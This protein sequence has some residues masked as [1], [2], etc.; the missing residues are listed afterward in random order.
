[1]LG[2]CSFTVF[3]GFSFAICNMAVFEATRIPAFVDGVMDSLH[4]GFPDQ[5]H[6]TI[7][8]VIDDALHSS[9]KADHVP[10]ELLECDLDFDVACPTGWADVGD[11]GACLA[12]MSYAGPCDYHVEFG[13]LLPMDKYLKAAECDARFPCRSRCE[14]DFEQVCPA[15][16]RDDA[17]AGCA[18]PHDY[19][20]PC[21]ARKRFALISVADRATFGR[22][23]GV[24]WP[25]RKSLQHGLRMERLAMHSTWTET[26]IID[27]NAPCP[28][29]WRIERMRSCR[30]PSEY[31]GQCSYSFTP[32]NYTA[33]M[34]K[35][36]AG[37]C[38][39]EWPCVDKSIVTR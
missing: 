35:A 27:Y 21:V 20:G 19:A 28:R 38:S 39:A 34:K 18:A 10:L 3:V 13:K 2:L 8:T 24:R 23:C 9:A 37:V 30:A 1:M 36:W 7:Q 33:E 5:P 17:A 6:I 12:P 29:G 4:D 14:E 32:A 15:G 31:S 22:Q 25:C 26:C 16:W 11:G